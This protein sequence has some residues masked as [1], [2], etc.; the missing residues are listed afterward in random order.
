MVYQRN[1]RVV[2]HVARLVGGV[3]GGVARVGDV[4]PDAAALS[5]ALAVIRTNAKALKTYIANSKALLKHGVAEGLLEAIAHIEATG[6]LLGCICV[7]C[8]WYVHYLFC[9]V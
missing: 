6:K 3:G 1:E 2:Q 5:G 4:V 8:F 9:D 7:W